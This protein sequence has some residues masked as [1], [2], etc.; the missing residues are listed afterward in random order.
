MQLCRCKRYELKRV[1]YE[2]GS[3]ANITLQEQ[4]TNPASADWGPFFISVHLSYLL[5]MSQL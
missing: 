5:R 2:N 4:V 1:E 3:C